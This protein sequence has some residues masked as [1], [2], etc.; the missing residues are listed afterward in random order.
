MKRAQ[1]I[2]DALTE[3][4]ARTAG[5]QKATFAAGCFWGVEAAFR[6]LEG[7]VKTT[8]GYAGGY[9]PDPSY[10]QVC[11]GS[12]GHAEAVE[13]IFDPARV[14][15]GQL[16]GRFWTV[17]DPTSLNRQG[18][19]VGDQYRSALFYH[20]DGQKKEIDRSLAELSKSGRFRRPIVTRVEPAGAFYP[21]EKYH[22]QYHEKR[23]GFCAFRL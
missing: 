4:Q 16:L 8:V 3:E 10:E 21:A 2:N 22:Q 9:L 7:V 17:H 15:Y 18:P 11:T 14:S 5:Y 12:T 13:V 6:G 19:D 1:T 20:D 23:G